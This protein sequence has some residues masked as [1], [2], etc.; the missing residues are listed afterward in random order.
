[1]GVMDGW[2]LAQFASKQSTILAPVLFNRLVDVHNV[3]LRCLE[4]FRVLS[5]TRPGVSPLRG[6]TQIRMGW[7]FLEAVA[8]GHGCLSVTKGRNHFSESY[9]VQCHTTILWNT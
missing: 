7:T 9:Y 8:I 1:M 2:I 3:T 6:T 5:R 4:H